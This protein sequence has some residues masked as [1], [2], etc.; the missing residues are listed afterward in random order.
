LITSHPPAD[1]VRN[2]FAFH[3][4]V[5]DSTPSRAAAFLPVDVIANT[6]ALMNSIA[7]L[8][9]SRRQLRIIAA[10]V[11]FLGVAVAKAQTLAPDAVTLARYD[12][13]RNGQLEPAERAAM[14]AAQGS[15]RL[16]SPDMARA[17]E[18]RASGSSTGPIELSPFEVVEDT[19][20]IDR[21]SHERADERL[22]HARYQRCL[23][24]HGEHGRHRRLH[25]VQC[26]Q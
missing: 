22:R 5:L 26:R 16:T 25:G 9:R 15:T 10:A 23:P 4:T 19:R 21:G 6:P 3:S 2:L 12:T 11:S 17:T 20:V 7:S 1:A 14:E 24:L 8:V 18:D 13:N